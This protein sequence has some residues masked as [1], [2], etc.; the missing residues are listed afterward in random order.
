MRPG[1][2][3]TPWEAT[4]W[5]TTQC[6]PHHTTAQCPNRPSPTSVA[7]TS[8]SLSPRVTSSHA[9]WEY[10]SRVQLLGVRC[11]C[12]RDMTRLLLKRHCTSMCNH[13]LLLYSH[14]THHPLLL[15]SLQMAPTCREAD[16]KQ[17]KD[18]MLGVTWNETHPSPF[19]TSFADTFVDQDHPQ[20]SVYR[21]TLIACDAMR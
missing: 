6:P 10:M 19:V 12:T 4:P 18:L 2:Q 11:N 1:V 14:S 20:V 9:C 3:S 7:I 16:G 15:Y 17:N 21:Y 8:H 13:T 5:S